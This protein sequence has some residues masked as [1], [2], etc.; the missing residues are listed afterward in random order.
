MNVEVD[1]VTQPTRQREVA[2][3]VEQ[4]TR[5]APDK[6]AVEME[7]KSDSPA[8]TAYE[9]FTLADLLKDRNEITQI[10]FRLAHRMRY[11][12]VHS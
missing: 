3:L 6:V 10:G 5:S 11:R 1:D 12:A 2:A 4:L 9:K 8:I 7:P